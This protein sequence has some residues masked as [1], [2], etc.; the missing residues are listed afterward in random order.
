MSN[1]FQNNDS[2]GSSDAG[3]GRLSTAGGGVAGR[4]GLRGVIVAAK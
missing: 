3:W 1:C 2:G 4:K